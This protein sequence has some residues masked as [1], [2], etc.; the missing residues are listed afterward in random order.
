MV[1]F[2]I[3]SRGFQVA[4]TRILLALDGG[5]GIADGKR[6]SSLHSGVVGNWETI[7]KR[8]LGNGVSARLCQTDPC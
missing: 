4:L 6:F 5:L 2:T 8:V 3:S 1:S 7:Q